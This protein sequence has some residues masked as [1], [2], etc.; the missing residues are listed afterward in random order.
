MKL[1]VLD[2]TG[3]KIDEVTLN[4][5]IFGAPVSN[6]L[7]AQAVRVRLINARAGTASTKD[8]GDVRGG[9]RKPW[10]QKGTGR[11]RH[12]STRSPIWSGGGVAHGPHFHKP[13]KAMPKTMRNA[14]LFSALTDK[15]NAKNVVI[16]DSIAL[17]Q[18]KTKQMAAV[19]SALPVGKKV[20]LVLPESNQDLQ[21]SSRN[22]PHVKLM[23]A[24]VLHAYEVLHYQTVVILKDSLTTLEET[25]LKTAETKPA[26]V[27]VKAKTAAKPEVTKESG[28]SN[29]ESGKAKP[30]P[31]AAAPKA[32]AKP[33]AKK[34]EG[35]K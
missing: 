19:I 4:P 12:G 21:R 17:D 5:A 24:R 10:R 7:M 18:P 31:K 32:A 25:F 6:A 35:D 29:L 1:D 28:S 16:V 2:Q 15:V 26:K 20:L 34:T 9:G 3:K 22:L 33:R 30:Q 13:E 27:E 23:P 8:R 11:A 14:A